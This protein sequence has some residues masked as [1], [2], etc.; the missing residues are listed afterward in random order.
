MD[1]IREMILE[2]IPDDLENSVKIMGLEKAEYLA[3]SLS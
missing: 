1:D 3:E 2:Y